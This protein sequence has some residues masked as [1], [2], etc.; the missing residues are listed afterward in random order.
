MELFAFTLEKKGTFKRI[1]GS[2]KI[3]STPE[4]AWSV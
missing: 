1:Y 3:L 2:I 4:G